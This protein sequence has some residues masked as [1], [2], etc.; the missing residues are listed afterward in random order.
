MNKVHGKT[1]F[2]PKLT[3]I[4]KVMTR[5]LFFCKEWAAFFS[6]GHKGKNLFFLNPCGELLLNFLYMFS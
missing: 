4:S 1:I 5:N 3:F 6:I 2:Y